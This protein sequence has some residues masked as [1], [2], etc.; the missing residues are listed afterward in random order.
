VELGCHKGDVMLKR[1]VW[2]LAC[3]VIPILLAT[4]NTVAQDDKLTYVLRV[5]DVDVF[6]GS[7]VIAV[8]FQESFP[9]DKAAENEDNWRV[10]A[11]DRDG[12]TRSYQPVAAKVKSRLSQLVNLTMGVNLGD[13]GELDPKTHKIIVRYQQQNLPSVTLGPISK[14]KEKKTFTAAKGKKDADIYF[15]GSA[16]GQRGSG[17]LYSIEAKAGYLHSLKGAGAIGGKASFVSDSGSKIDPDSIT[18]SATYQKIFVLRS[19]WGIILNSDFLGGEFDKENTTRNLTTELDATLVLPSKRFGE[20]NFATMDF[21]GGFEG[22]HN[23]KHALNP[24]G[25]GNIWRPKFGVNAYFVA[26]AP[27]FFNR[28]NLSANYILRLPQTAE[29]F[30]QEVNGTKITFLTTKPRHDVGIDL[31]LMFAP[32]YGFTI[33][34]RYG[35]LPPDF[36]LVDHKVSAGFTLQLKQANK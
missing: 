35:S 29:P 9:E 25:L 34:Y 1:I 10:I 26:L 4:D 7:K 8:Q 17:P 14:K 20:N 12:N 30:T 36:K 6:E 24:K 16:T 11:I 19:P 18:A 27:K 32:S 31:G 5:A 28:I 13:G 33:S 2:L 23:Y 22:G 15:N 3:L 21:M